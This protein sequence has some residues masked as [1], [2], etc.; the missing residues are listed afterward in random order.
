MIAALIQATTRRRMAAGMRVL[1]AGLAVVGLLLSPVAASA[2]MLGCL[3]HGGGGN[4]VMDTALAPHIQSAG[5]P[6]SCCDPGKDHGPTK[7]QDP[8]CAQACATMC[9][10]SAA[11]PSPPTALAATPD[12]DAATPKQV[13]LLKPHEPGRIERPPDR[14]PVTAGDAL[15]EPRAPTAGLRPADDRSIPGVFP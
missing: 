14:S 9:G 7:H 1:M 11:L 13:A 6:R 5:T 8:S 2:A 12:R 3:H 10:V 15:A 4:T